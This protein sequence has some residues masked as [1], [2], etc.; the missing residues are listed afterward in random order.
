MGRSTKVLRSTS[1]RP[2]K[3]EMKSRQP[4]AFVT[5][6]GSGIGRAVAFKLGQVGIRVA[7]CD[8]TQDNLEETSRT[9]S[10]E[11]IAVS[12]HLCDVSQREQVDQVVRAILERHERIDSLVNNAGVSKRNPI[13]NSGDAIWHEILATNLNGVY[14]CAQSGLLGMPMGGRIVNI[15]SISGKVGTAGYTAYCASKHAV[16]GFT[17][18]LALEVAP[19][20]ITVNAVCP[21]WSET[22]MA[23]ADIEESAR[24]EGSSYHQI[25]AAV[26]KDIPMGEFIS[27]ARIADF[28]YFLISPAAANIT[29]QALN[30][31]GGEV[32][33]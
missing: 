29:G 23:R 16:I 11:G 5:G 8:R 21:G 13:G 1:S 28:V 18:A 24:L 2:G 30:I 31:S 19:R 3:S 6:A 27:P 33:H 17:R 10:E 4:V 15:A 12:A 20:K 32:M 7:I 9:M 22:G 26:L 14:F 25:E